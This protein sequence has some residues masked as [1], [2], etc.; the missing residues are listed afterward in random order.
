MCNTVLSL[1]CLLYRSDEIRLLFIYDGV[2]VIVEKVEGCC[3]VDSAGSRGVGVASGAGGGAGGG[4][5]GKMVAGAARRRRQDGNKL[6][7]SDLCIH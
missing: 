5:G 7:I 6:Y 2:A 1:L 3:G 4:G